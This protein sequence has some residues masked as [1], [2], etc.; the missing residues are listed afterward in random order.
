MCRPLITV[1]NK[2]SDLNWIKLYDT[3]MVI[4]KDLFSKKDEKTHEYYAACK[5]ENSLTVI[6]QVLEDFLK[7]NFPLDLPEICMRL[8]SSNTFDIPFL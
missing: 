3:L 1:A 8:T 2:M 7:K 5:D 4:L 6:N